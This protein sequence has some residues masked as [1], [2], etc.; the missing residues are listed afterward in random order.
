MTIVTSYFEV[1]ET[2]NK[3]LESFDSSPYFAHVVLTAKR[4]VKE[5]VTSVE[6]LEFGSQLHSV[7]IVPVL[8]AASGIRRP[9]WVTFGQYNWKQLRFAIDRQLFIMLLHEHENRLTKT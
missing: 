4:S 8:R 7:L 6:T 3:R 9:H 1:S 5:H 2:L